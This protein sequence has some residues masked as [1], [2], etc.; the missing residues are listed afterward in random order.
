MSVS[1]VPLSGSGAAVARGTRAILVVSAV[2]VTVA[3]WLWLIRGSAS[4]AAHSPLL[5]PYPGRLDASSLVSAAVMWE[6]MIL[7]MMTPVFLPWAVTFARLTPRTGVVP[8]ATGYFCVWAIYGAAGAALQVVLQQSA[9]LRAGRVGIV[10]AGAILIAAGLF[11]FAPFRRA[12]L[13]HCRNPLTYFLSR[14][15]EGPEGGF[16]LG[17][18]HA[19]YCV[20]CCWLLMLTGLAMGVMN[21]AWMAV[22]TVFIVAEQVL[23]HGDRIGRVGGAGL[24]AWGIALLLG[25]AP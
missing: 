2:V 3:A 21:L 1:V 16:R 17:L 22:L 13:K 24:A 12:C 4:H 11:Q 23:P 9:L 7:A 8:L 19:A 14:W 15:R 18:F 20:G 25:V 10:A 6:S 5:A